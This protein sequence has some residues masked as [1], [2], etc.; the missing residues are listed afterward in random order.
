MTAPIL[1]HV[2]AVDGTKLAVHR[3]GAGRPVVMLHGL[4]SSAEVNWIKFGTAQK[5][6]D[7]GF[8]VIMPDLRAHGL[9]EAPHGEYSSAVLVDDLKDV[10]AHYQLSGFDLVGFSLGAR[11]VLNAV[12][13]GVQPERLAVVGMGWEGL[14]GWDK[15]I[16][17]F[18]DAIDR[19]D[20]IRM[21]DPAFFAVSFMKTQKVDRAAA[22]ALLTSL[23]GTDLSNLSAVTMPTKVINGAKDNDNGSAQTLVEK[24]PNATY[25][26][27]PGTHMSCVSEPALG[28]TLVEFLS[29]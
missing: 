4:F 16:A 28:E 20:D 26:E 5:V 8:D 14:V 18:V 12:L 7:A 3:L 2:T 19:F 21:G 15:R 6:A 9:S 23:S 29:R 13:A 25:A 1:E 10:I 27:I 17:F 22:R 24:L 11:T